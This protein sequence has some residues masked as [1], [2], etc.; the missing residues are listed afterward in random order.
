VPRKSRDGEFARLRSRIDLEDRL[1]QALDVVTTEADALSL[2]GD[3]LTEAFGPSVRLLIPD[4]MALRLGPA[5]IVA[6][7]DH[8]IDADSCTAF[9]RGAT[10]TVSSSNHFDACPHL[11][12]SAERVSGVC[13]PVTA[14]GRRVGVVQWTG[15]ERSPLDAIDISTIESVAY[16]LALRLLVIRTDAGSGEPIRFVTELVPFSV[17]ICILDDFE[18]YNEVHG[19][20]I[21]DQALRLFARS[22]TAAV[23]PNDIVGRTDID[24]FTVVFPSTSALDAAHALERVRETLVLSLSGGDLPSFTGS[25]GVSDSNQGDSID[26]IIETAE[27]AVAL[28]SKAGQNRVVVAGEETDGPAEPDAEG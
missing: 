18:A 8:L 16:L 5:L 28:A 25:F 3:A 13:V 23:R 20:E 19:H 21:G 12:R 15:P 17:A 1:R 26:A 9:R 4:P 11:R 7:D 22:L 27:I 10:S 24:Q 2:V 14:A 6:N